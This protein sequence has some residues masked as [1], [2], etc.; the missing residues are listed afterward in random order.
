MLTQLC[1]RRGTDHKPRQRCWAAWEQWPDDIQRHQ[2]RPCWYVNCIVWPITHSSQRPPLN[3]E[4]FG[5]PVWAFR[6]T[7]SIK[8]RVPRRVHK[9]A[10]ERGW[11][12]WHS[13]KP[14][15]A[16][17]HRHRH[18]STYAEEQIDESRSMLCDHCDS[19]AMTSPDIGGVTT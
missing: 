2:G 8:P 4:S 14:Y 19:D 3:T 11:K 9:I 7:V 6:S 16:R 5:M 1:H 13:C 15:R 17:L 12:P 18:D 10:L